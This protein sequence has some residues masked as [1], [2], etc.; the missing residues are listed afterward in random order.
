MFSEVYK[1][2][3]LSMFIACWGRCLAAIPWWAWL[4]VAIVGIIL[5]IVNL[6]VG[7][8]LAGETIA[9]ITVLAFFLAGV[10]GLLAAVGVTLGYCAVG[11]VR[12]LT[13]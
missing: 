4:I 11:C 1:V 7:V 12:I 9:S 13:G 6:V 10:K 8:L 5:G 3:K 2:D